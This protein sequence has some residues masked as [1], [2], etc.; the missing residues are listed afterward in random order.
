VF[1][2][3]SIVHRAASAL[4]P[5]AAISLALFLFGCG[6]SAAPNVVTPPPV[7]S[8]KNAQLFGLHIHY[9]PTTTPWPTIG[10]GGVRLWDT[11]T[12]W[13]QLEKSQGVYDFSHLDDFLSE[14]KAHGLSNILYT[15]G[16][17]PQWASTNPTDNACD[18]SNLTAPGGCDLPNDINADGSGS[19]QTWINFVT[20]LA[21]HVNDATYLQSHAHIGYWEP[22]NEWY[23]NGVVNSYPWNTVS[24]NATYAQMVRMAEDLRCIVTG[25]GSVN[26]SPCTGTAIDG[27]AKIL[28]PSDGDIA[29]GSIQVF[30]NYLYCNGTGAN[31]PI[32]GSQCTTGTRGSAAADI[33]DSHFYEGNGRPAEDLATDVAP[34]KAVLSAA[35]QAKPFWS[36]EGSWNLDSYVPDPDVEASWV[37]RYYLIGWSSGFAQMYW[38]AYDVPATSSSPGYGTLW[39]PNGGLDKAGVAYGQIYNW[40]VGSTL[41]TPCTANGTVWTCGLTLGNGNAAEVIWDTSQTCANGVCTTSNQSVPAAWANY[42]SLNGT[43]NAITT[44][45]TVAVGL[46]PILLTVTSSSAP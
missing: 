34:Y 45:A 29:P 21:Q 3:S 42:Q 33:I 4:A 27:T 25:T 41:T 37:A 12:R 36:G 1:K 8:S 24:L 18:Y 23:R 19:D 32:S 2:G 15:F 5:F 14:A 44:S 26:G 13:A 20:A 43:N 22:W 30:Q 35:D 17:V 40:V 28:S 39:T 11:D 38:Y 31:A 16:E 10:F 46:K 6:G 7:T 9:L